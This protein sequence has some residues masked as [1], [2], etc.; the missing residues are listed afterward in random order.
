MDC[1]KCGT[2]MDYKEDQKNVLE[3]LGCA[4]CLG[5]LVSPLAWLL[6]PL[7]FFLPKTRYYRCPKCGAREP[8][9]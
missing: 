2:P 3:F 1:P 9:R 4:G 8:V 7:A 6:A 5:C